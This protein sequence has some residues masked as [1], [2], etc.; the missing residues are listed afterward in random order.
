[1]CAGSYSTSPAPARSIST[2]AAPAGCWASI[3]RPLGGCWRSCAPTASWRPGPR[4]ARPA[5]RP[6]STATSETDDMSTARKNRRARKTGQMVYVDARKLKPSPENATLYRD[7]SARDADF[8][9][10]VESVR[11]EG[12]Q[13]PLLVSRDGYIVS[14]HQRQRA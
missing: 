12:V 13:A 6:T 5:A 4:A 10:L 7:R 2:A 1:R 8:A 14:G 11:N 9:R 3:T